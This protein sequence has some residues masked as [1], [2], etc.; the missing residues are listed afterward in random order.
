MPRSNDR[1]AGPLMTWPQ[2]ITDKRAR[3]ALQRRQA[4]VDDA[5]AYGTQLL[6][7]AREELNK[8]DTKSQ[9]LLGV[10]GVGLGTITGGLLAGSWSPHGLA[11]AV[12]W[13]WW[14]GV[15]AALVALVVLAGALYPRLSKAD[16]AR[17]SEVMYFADVLRFATADAVYDALLKSSV[18]DLERI[19]SQLHH[20][21]KIANRKYRLIRLGFWLSLFAIAATVG[22]VLGNLALG[23]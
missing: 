2:W 1:L 12:E 7:E 9:V 10:I 6:E 14:T 19:A 8:A 11:D 22:S 15:A 20:I 23:Q 16:R 3:A 17:T 18:L 4:A 13:L 5:C 21:S